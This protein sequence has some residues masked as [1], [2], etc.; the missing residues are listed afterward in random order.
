MK[1][2]FNPSLT[3]RQRKTLCSVWTFVLLLVLTFVCS[4]QLGVMTYGDLTKQSPETQAA[5]EQEVRILLKVKQLKHPLLFL[6]HP[7]FYF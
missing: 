2:F 6:N 4:F 3:V 1:T 7:C 5:V